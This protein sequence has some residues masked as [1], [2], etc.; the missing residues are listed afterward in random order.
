MLLLA[1][2][3]GAI[4]NAVW[5]I[6]FAI[7]FFGFIIFIHELGHFVTAKLNHVTVHEFSIGMGPVLF[8]RRKGIT[9]YSLRL[10]PIGGY[11]QMEGEDESSEDSGAFCNKKVWQRMVIVAAGGIM[12][13][14]FGLILCG[15]LTCTEDLIGTRTIARFYDSAVSCDYGLQ[16]EDTIIEVNGMHIFN[17]TDLSYAMVRDE[18]AVYDFTVLRDGEK[19]TLENVQFATQEIEGTQTVIFDFVLYGVEK[20]PWLVIKNAFLDTASTARIVW[21]TLFDMVTGRY[22]ITDL[23]GPIGTISVIADVATEA[24][25]GEKISQIVNIMAFITINIG[26]FNLIPIPA[27]DGGRLFFLLVE[28]IARRPILPKYEKYIHAAGMILLLGLVAVISIKD[29]VYLFK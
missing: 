13:I 8:K 26:V 25:A 17:A 14:L 6:L 5:P 24:V 1:I 21:L 28:G 22:G 12:N 16:A 27:L 29:I 4:W 20:T 19:I 15:V 2:S 7:I 3:I 11:V 9:Q 18:D 23:S 10:L